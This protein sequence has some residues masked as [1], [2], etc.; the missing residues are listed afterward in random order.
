MHRE[1]DGHFPSISICIALR[2]RPSG[3]A[4]VETDPAEADATTIR[5]R[6]ER[7]LAR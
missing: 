6:L 1:N 3:L 2:L 7:Y 5:N 4:Y